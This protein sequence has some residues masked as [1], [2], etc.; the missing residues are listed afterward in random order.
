MMLRHYSAGLFLQLW[1]RQLIHFT[2]TKR[3]IGSCF[4]LLVEEG[5]PL[6]DCHLLVQ[7]KKPGRGGEFKALQVY[8]MLHKNLIL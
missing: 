3:E 7:C 8:Y 5:Q 1:C 4:I 6:H 2:W